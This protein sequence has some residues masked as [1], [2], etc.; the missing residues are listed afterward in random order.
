MLR[1][2]RRGMGGSH[3]SMAAALGVLDEVWHPGAARARERLD[4]QH[5]LAVPVPSPGDRLLREGR[6]VIRRP[7]RAGT[8]G[9]GA[10]P[11]VSRAGADLSR[12]GAGPRP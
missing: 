12:A 1:W 6:V 3:G 11:D 2:L 9:G 5:E 4:A 10:G 7:G 8:D